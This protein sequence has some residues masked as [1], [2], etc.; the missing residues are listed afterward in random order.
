MKFYVCWRLKK[1]FKGQIIYIDLPPIDD[2]TDEN[3]GDEDGD[4]DITDL[5]GQQLS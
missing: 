2:V 1:L 3:S 4:V 5:L